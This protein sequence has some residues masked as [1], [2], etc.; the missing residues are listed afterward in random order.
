MGSPL[1]II[2]RR[3]PTNPMHRLRIG[4][5]LDTPLSLCPA[6]PFPGSQIPDPESQ[7]KLWMSL[8]VAGLLHL[9]IFLIAFILNLMPVE[10]VEEQ[11]IIPVQ[12][13]RVQPVVDET[14]APA[15]RA[16]AERRS[17]DFAPAPPALAPQVIN[18]QVVAQASPT[19]SAEKISMTNV[20][21]VA[22]PKTVSNAPRVQAATVSAINSVARG[23]TQPV[24]VNASA[25]PALSGPVEIDA[26]VGPSVGPQKVE[27]VTGTSIGTAPTA[28]N[29]GNA[30]SSVR[31]GVASNRDVLGTPDGKPLANVNTR[32]GTGL[33]SG[34]GGS[35]TGQGGTNAPC[36]DRPE[37]QAYIEGV[38]KRMYARWL[39]PEGVPNNKPVKLAFSLDASGSLLKAET[40][41]SSG[42]SDLDQSAV[43]AL[44]AASPFP[45]MNPSARCLSGTTL[46]GTFTSRAQ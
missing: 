12:L 10:I 44:R 25:A 22:A 13:L 1:N 4:V 32:V 3:Q 6:L 30:G 45:P 11:V 17:F 35:G 33:M 20:G 31:E 27:G 16:L 38:K 34:P 8:G 36:L 43:E 24:E 41:K 28:T 21:T 23:S 9:S 18:P 15:P 29:I 19:V 2:P 26:P 7:S 42:S 40:R 5:G 39:L 37:A 14:P 46:S